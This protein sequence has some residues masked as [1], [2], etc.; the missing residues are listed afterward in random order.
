MT[1]NFQSINAASIFGIGYLYNIYI[2]IYMH[3][4]YSQLRQKSFSK[5][6]YEL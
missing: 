1:K 4:T 3:Q 6:N 2:N 5:M